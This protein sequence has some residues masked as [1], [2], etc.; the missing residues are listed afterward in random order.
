M[1]WWWHR[2]DDGNKYC[3]LTDVTGS[4]ECSISVRL[5][6]TATAT[7]RKQRSERRDTRLHSV[8]CP[9]HSDHSILSSPAPET[10]P[11]YVTHILGLLLFYFTFMEPQLRLYLSCLDLRMSCMKPRIDT[12][13]RVILTHGPVSRSKIKVTCCLSAY[14]VTYWPRAKSQGDYKLL[15]LGVPFQIKK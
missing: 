12:I 7:W 14:N 8:C 6:T 1:M 13:V 11:P 9:S 4:C 15:R 2:G 3:W 10:C 5:T